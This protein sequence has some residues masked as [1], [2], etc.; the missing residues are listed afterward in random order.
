MVNIPGRLRR[1]RIPA[2]A[3]AREQRELQMIVRVDQTRQYPQP[4]QI[5]LDFLC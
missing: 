5:Q 3:Q 4:V 1:V 2:L